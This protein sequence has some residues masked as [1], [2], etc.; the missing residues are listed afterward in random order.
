MARPVRPARLRTLT[1]V[2]APAVALAVP[3][4]ARVAAPVGASGA[5]TPAGAAAPI[6][7]ATPYMGF[8][9]WSLESTNF[10][11]CG[12]ENW[13]TESH[14]LQQ[15]DVLAS[16]P[17]SH[18]YNY[19]HVDAGWNV[20]NG[21]NVSDDYARPTAGGTTCPTWTGPPSDHPPDPNQHNGRIAAGPPTPSA[22]A[23]CW[24]NKSRTLLA[25]S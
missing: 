3:A 6:V 17:K 21:K 11:G 14:V 15:A 25:K 1:C 8:S 2:T 22:M 9:T 10:P 12:G 16:K 13:L 4:A 18:G 5:G 19:V 20:D 23:T 7:A 24:N